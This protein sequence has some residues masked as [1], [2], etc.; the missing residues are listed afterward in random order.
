MFEPEVFRKRMYYIE[1]STCDIVGTFQCSPTVIRS[2]PAVIRRTHS[3]SGPVELFPPCPSL[4]TLL[5]D[6]VI[7]LQT[8]CNLFSRQ[9]ACD[10]NKTK[11]KIFLVD[12]ILLFKH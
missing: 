12:W 3:D 11:L 7:Y 1:E 8:A 9:S 4:V 5:T 2:P 10:Q 6:T